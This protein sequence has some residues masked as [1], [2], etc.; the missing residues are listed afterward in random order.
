MRINNDVTVA[1]GR[2][3]IVLPLKPCNI[4]NA[5]SAIIN[6]TA[7][8]SHSQIAW[9]GFIND[10]DMIIKRSDAATNRVLYS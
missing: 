3:D 6:Y 2:K 1:A 7:G 10:T 4:N 5:R 9:H 8:C